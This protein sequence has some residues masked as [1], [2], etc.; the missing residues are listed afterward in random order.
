MLYSRKPRAASALLSLGVIFFTGL[1]SAVQA[2]LQCAQPNNGTYSA[3]DSLVL[4]WSSDGSSPTV[5]DIK[6]MSAT[7]NCNNGISIANVTI[8]TW[9]AP[10]TWTVPSVGNATTAGGTTGTC[11]SNS[12]H[13]EYTGVATVTVLGFITQEK[14]FTISCDTITIL[15]AANNSITTTTATTTTTVATTKSKTTSSTSTSSSSASPT[16]SN[17][18]SDDDSKPK[19]FIIV[20]VAIVAGLIL[21]LVAFAS[22][23]Y[24]RN[25]RIKRME[26]AVMPWSNQPGS[27]FSKVSSMDEGHRA[28]GSINGAA[29]VSNK[30]QPMTPQPQKSY[31][32]GDEYGSQYGLGGGY[33]NY[34][35]G[36]NQDEYY[37]PY[38]AASRAGYGAS[39]LNSNTTYYN[40]STPYLDPRDPYQQPAPTGYFPPPPPVVPS[41]MPSTVSQLNTVSEIAPSSGSLRGPQVILPEKGSPSTEDDIQMK[42]LMKSSE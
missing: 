42:V 11:P 25:Q 10:Y 40:N 37:D 29:A 36:N 35:N 34:N 1:L 30:P 13:V 12:F 17:V 32:S 23:W 31:Y 33:D 18:T 7:L 28:P 26:D 20:I 5:Q 2:T 19:T 6:S 39:P 3:G 8:T 16:P 22:W 38:Y 14:A 21:F 41:P 24:L 27:Q 4:N 9:N 15:P